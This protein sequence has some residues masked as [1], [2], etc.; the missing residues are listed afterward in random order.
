MVTIIRCFENLL[1]FEFTCQLILS[2]FEFL[3]LTDM[4]FL[5]ILDLLF[6]CL[7][8]SKQLFELLRLDLHLLLQTCVGVLQ[9]DGSL[10]TLLQ[11]LLQLALLALLCLRGHIGHK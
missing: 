4:F 7:Q 6:R 1:E 2:L 8:L 5:Q 3:P 9:V 10:L 11:L